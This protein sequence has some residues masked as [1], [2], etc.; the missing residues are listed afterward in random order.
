MFVNDECKCGLPRHGRVQ[1]WVTKLV[2]TLSRCWRKQ[3]FGC[4]IKIK[5]VVNV[6]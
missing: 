3:S 5:V 1:F 4:V 2:V 6:L